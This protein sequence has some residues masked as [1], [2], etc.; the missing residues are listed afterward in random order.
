M[1][2]I[3]GILLG[4]GGASLL[5]TRGS[6]AEGGKVPVYYCGYDASAGLYVD[7]GSIAPVPALWG[8]ASVKAIYSYGF[9]P[10]DVLAYVIIVSGNQA[11]GF[12]SALTINGVTVPGTMNAPTFDAPNNET[13]FTL[14]PSETGQ[15]LFGLTDGVISSVSLN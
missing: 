10:N 13:T 2:G 8:G 5:V 11:A 14:F 6:Y 7:F 9:V 12:I 4:G 1:S 15:T 3:M